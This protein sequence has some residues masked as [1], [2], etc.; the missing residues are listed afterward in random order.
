MVPSRNG[1]GTNALLRNPPDVFP[2]RFGHDSFAAHI[3]EAMTAGAR[4]RIIANPRIALDLDDPDD[5]DRFLAQPA[6][7]ETY[8]VLLRL[9]VKERLSALWRLTRSS[10]AD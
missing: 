2:S 7:G 10:S 8:R 3:R 4:L 5:I 1:M 9:C 6:A